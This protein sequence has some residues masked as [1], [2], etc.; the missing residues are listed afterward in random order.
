MRL[1]KFLAQSGATSR[2]KADDLI[3]AGE[4]TVNGKIVT[5]MGIQ[6]DPE[7]DEVLFRTRPVTLKGEFVYLAIN[8]PKGY[9]TTLTD[10]FNRE[11]TKR[12]IPKDLKRIGLKPIGRLDKDTEGLL[13]MTNDLEIIN[14]LTHPRYEKEKEYIVK[15]DKPINT[16]DIGQLEKGI[17]LEDKETLPCVLKS[18]PKQKNKVQITIKEG[19]KRQIRKMFQHLGYSVIYL[20]RIRVGNL[21]LGEGILSDLKVGQSKLITKKCLQA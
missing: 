1:N 3:A 5:E 13:V 6:V 9:I 10:P 12:L 15:L 20:Q 11:T 4:V 8:K 16:K 18:N 17:L 19:R 21:T 14:Q 7:K 2:R